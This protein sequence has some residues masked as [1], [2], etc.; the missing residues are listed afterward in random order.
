MPNLLI[1]AGG[2]DS[3]GESDEIVRLLNQA[4]QISLEK[5]DSR[6]SA[7]LIQDIRLMAKLGCYDQAIE[8]VKRSAPNLGERVTGFM[9]F[10]IAEGYMRRNEIDEA[11]A[12]IGEFRRLLYRRCAEAMYQKKIHGTK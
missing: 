7:C 9:S 10:A 1:V 5:V 3:A 8:L 4:F 12:F 2:Q 11:L 6:Q